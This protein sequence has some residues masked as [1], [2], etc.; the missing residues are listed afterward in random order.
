MTT[1]DKKTNLSHLIKKDYVE[2]VIVQ[3]LL[4]KVWQ[5]DLI[6]LIMLVVCRH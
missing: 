1:S 3:M 5:G 4:K 2:A 6:Y